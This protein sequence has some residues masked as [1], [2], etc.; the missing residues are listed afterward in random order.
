MNLVNDFFEENHFPKKNLFLKTE[1]I[2]LFRY[3][4]Q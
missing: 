3:V 1:N 4:S 2:Q